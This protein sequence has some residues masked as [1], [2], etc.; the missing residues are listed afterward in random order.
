MYILFLTAVWANQPPIEDGFG[1]SFQSSQ[2]PLG[3]PFSVLNLQDSHLLSIHEQ[4]VE[5]ELPFGVFWYGEEYESVWVDKNANLS[6]GESYT[7]IPTNLCSEEY[8]I[9]NPS[10]VAIDYDWQ[11]HSIRYGSFGAYP[12]R[13]FAVEWSGTY[14]DAT[15]ESSEGTVQI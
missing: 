13:A 14:Q 12:H 11:P 5:I 1:M 4:A 6:F 10:V 15:G 7:G 2:S 8:T 9:T 3:P